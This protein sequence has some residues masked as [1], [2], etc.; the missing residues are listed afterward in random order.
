M[1]SEKKKAVKANSVDKTRML[2]F[3][4]IICA[5]VITTVLSVYIFSTNHPTDKNNA[6]TNN[7]TSTSGPYVS[8]GL[9]QFNIVDGKGTKRTDQAFNDMKAFLD[10][11]SANSRCEVSGSAG[12]GYFSV[13]A[14]TSDQKQLL[15]AY[16]CTQADAKMYAININGEWKTISPTNRFDNF[17][18]PGCDYLQQNDISPE[19]APVCA[20]G[21][22]SATGLIYGSPKYLNR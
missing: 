5:A 1:V 21:F 4:L 19:I 15:L 13:V 22:D 14:S 11:E 6:A 7:S 8:L 20:N 12:Q 17:G 18:I 3:A 2:L 16:G 10:K 9:L